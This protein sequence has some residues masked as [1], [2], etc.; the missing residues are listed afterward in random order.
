MRLIRIDRYTFTLPS[1]VAGR[2]R[3]G[4]PGPYLGRGEWTTAY[5]PRSVRATEQLGVRV[6]PHHPYLAVGFS[7]TV[8]ITKSLDA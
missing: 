7:L 2:T 3:A 5:Y 6:N 8:K 4:P 1:H